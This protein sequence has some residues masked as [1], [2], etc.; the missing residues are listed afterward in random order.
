MI[1]R[2]S[3]CSRKPSREIEQ[4]YLDVF[5]EEQEQKRAN[6]RRQQLREEEEKQREGMTMKERENDERDSSLSRRYVYDSEKI[7]HLTQ[8]ESFHCKVWTESAIEKVINTLTDPIGKV[9]QNLMEKKLN[10]FLHSFYE[11]YDLAHEM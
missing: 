8:S 9:S 5:D 11:S 6:E 1:K 3:D 2:A 4:D 10:L 7:D